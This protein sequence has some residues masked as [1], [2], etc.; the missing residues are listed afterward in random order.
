[1]TI[2]IPLADYI[3]IDAKALLTLTDWENS[4]D[5]RDS[6]MGIRRDHGNV[7]VVCQHRDSEG[8]R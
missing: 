8:K 3:A 5:N 7:S 6:S 2:Q 1:M 4:D